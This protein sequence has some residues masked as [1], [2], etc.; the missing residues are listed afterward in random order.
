MKCS[1]TAIVGKP[2]SGKS[3]L[4]N[5]I[6]G[7]KI[8]IVTPKVQTTRFNIRGV[9][10]EGNCQL[11][12]T[13]TPGLFKPREGHKLEEFIVD[14]AL[15]ALKKVDNVILLIDGTDQ[16]DLISYQEILEKINKSRLKD[17]NQ[18]Y[19]DNLIVVINKIDLSF[20][21]TQWLS[22]NPAFDLPLIMI[23]AK[24]GQGVK[25]LLQLLQ[26]RAKEGPWL[27]KEDEYTNIT[28]RQLA[29]EITREELY[30]QLRD[31]LPYSL[32]VDTESWQELDEG[33][34]KIYQSIIIL[35]NSQKNIVIGEKGGMIKKIGIAARKQIES[36][37]DKKVHLFLHVKV[38]ED[39]IDKLKIGSN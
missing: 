27:F 8:S 14:N 19:K 32:K 36:L 13:D 9:Y 11:I 25:E 29:E 16:P 3:T 12:F 17:T 15:K 18:N 20:D 5:Q 24:E 1:L 38:R 33:E 30:M 34:I 23:S 2:N 22:L 21:K 26:T 39:W 28:E 4:F 10:N 6:L 7:Q 35:K 37:L 31:E